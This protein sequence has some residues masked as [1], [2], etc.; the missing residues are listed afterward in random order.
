MCYTVVAFND[1]SKGYIYNAS[2][3]MLIQ[4]MASKSNL[5][6]KMNEVLLSSYV[7]AFDFLLMNRGSMFLSNCK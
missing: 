5:M 1:S 2:T 6:V 4:Y 3:I 7:C